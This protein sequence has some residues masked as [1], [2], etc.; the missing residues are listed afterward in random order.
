MQPVEDKKITEIEEFN[1]LPLKDRIDIKAKRIQIIFQSLLIIGIALT[2]I[3]TWLLMKFGMATGIPINITGESAGVLGTIALLGA[4][5]LGVGILVPHQMLSDKEVRSFISQEKNK[6][7]IIWYHILPSTIILGATIHAL[8]RNAENFFITQLSVFAATTAL[9]LIHFY[10]SGDEK[11]KNASTALFLAMVLNFAS[12]YF[13]I[14]NA[15]AIRSIY[16]LKINDDTDW[17]IFICCIQAAMSLMAVIVFY[18]AR[19]NT[20][21]VM[22]I[23]LFTFICVVC[24]ALILQGERL[25]AVSLIANGNGGG[26]T[27]KFQIDPISFKDKNYLKN[28]SAIEENNTVVLCYWYANSDAWYVS[29]PQSK[30]VKVCSLDENLKHQNGITRI[31]KKYMDMQ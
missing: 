12:F 11:N 5:L 8:A 30:S 19:K 7:F 15:L 17:V 24:L 18:D 21:G 14:T 9:A 2:T 22:S 6:L 31:P 16:D 25:G 20:N 28:I 4:G 26:I 1:S 3:G 13:V 27:K 23:S 10:F 29:I